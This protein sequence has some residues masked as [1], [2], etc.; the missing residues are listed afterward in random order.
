VRA[1]PGTYGEGVA[2]EMLVESGGKGELLVVAEDFAGERDPVE[3]ELGEG[4][5]AFRR[6]CGVRPT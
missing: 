2:L 1:A 6:G 4:M 3:E 5:I